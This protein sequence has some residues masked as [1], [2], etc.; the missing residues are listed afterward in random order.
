MLGYESARGLFDAARE[1]ATDVQRVTK[2]LDVLERGEGS[3]AY[4]AHSFEARIRVGRTCDRTANMAVTRAD[5]RE[6]LSRRLEADY[7]VIDAAC[8]V[9]YG[10]DQMHDGLAT[11]VPSWWC[12][13]IYYHYLAL[14]KWKDVASFLCYSTEHVIRS[15]SAALETAD[16]NR[17]MW[18]RM[19]VGFAES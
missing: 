3:T 12:D 1:A 11:L 4:G 5:R 16:A 9:L 2:E 19:G 17:A 10:N 7:A 15:A 13:A 14:W 8:A 18:T 6:Q